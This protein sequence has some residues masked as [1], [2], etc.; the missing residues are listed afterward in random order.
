MFKNVIAD[1]EMWFN[2]IFITKIINFSLNNEYFIME[3][4]INNKNLK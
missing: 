4:N 2:V 3:H 1:L